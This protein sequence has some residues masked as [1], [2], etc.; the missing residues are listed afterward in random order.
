MMSYTFTP[1]YFIYIYRSLVNLNIFNDVICKFYFTLQ[2]EQETDR[3]GK[4]TK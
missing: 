1:N 3:G 4:K 2:I